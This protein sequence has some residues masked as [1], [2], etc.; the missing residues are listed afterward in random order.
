MIDQIGKYYHT[1]KYL[2][3]TQ[4]SYRIKGLLRGNRMVKVENIV[5]RSVPASR[6][7]TLIEDIPAYTGWWENDNFHFVNITHSFPKGIDWNCFDYG[8]LWRFNLN[9]FEF[10]HQPDMTKENGVRLIDD[11]IK[12]FD[13][14]EGGRKAFPTSLRLVNWIQ[15]ICKHRIRNSDFDQS[16]W[17][18]AQELRKNLEFQLMGNH[19]LENAFGLLYAGVYFNNIEL[20][21]EAIAILKPQLKEQ[22]LTDGAHF[23]ITPMYHQLM[24]YRILDCVNLIKNNP[25]SDLKP[26]LKLL[27]DKASLMLGW[28]EAMCFQNKK[29]PKINDS[30]DGIAPSVEAL[31]AYAKRLD[32]NPLKIQLSDSGYR[33]VRK[34]KYETLLD[35]GN[36]GPDYI[37]GHAHSDT[38]S[39]VLQYE[40]KPLI[41]DTG[42]STYEKNARRNLERSTQSHN[43]VMVA[44]LEQSEV[45]GGFRVARRA[46]IIKLVEKANQ[47]VASHDGY[48]K[49]GVI[50]ERHF[51][52]TDKNLILTDQLTGNQTGTAFLHFHPDIQVTLEAKTIIGHFG[53]IIFKNADAV[54]LDRYQYAVGY[55]HTVLATKAIIKFKHQLITKIIFK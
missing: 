28:T 46:R 21:K 5:S 41:V 27:Q 42:I 8:I 40:N 19:L 38:F 47:I 15:F 45:W 18:Q 10:L 13:A 4:I 33:M 30:T 23:E 35:V 29:L 12:K 6:L 3:W 20:I 31:E 22:I 43:T 39:F 26:L 54:R 9:Y 49:S 17:H 50:H 1:L 37:P 16:I 48:Q 14:L 25:L 34:N 7:L 53:N 52:F 2:K 51:Q 44:G 24:L 36:I 32:I 11:F 55:N